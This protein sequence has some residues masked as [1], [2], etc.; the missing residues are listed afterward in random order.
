MFIAE[1]DWV[2][3]AG[4]E[5]TDE[6]KVTI[7]ALA[8]LL[9]LGI[10]HDY[11]SRVQ[12]ILVFP[13]IVKQLH[14]SGLDPRSNET[15]W[16]RL[17]VRGPV[18]NRIRIVALDAAAEPPTMTVEVD[19]TGRRYLEDRDTTAVLAGSRSRAS[20]RMRPTTAQA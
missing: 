2:G 7:A 18:V 15:G 1:K 13:E 6:V 3:C 16:T 20:R 11:F 12:A 17:V 14:T 19:L 4:L 8:C 10:E 9:L 5:I